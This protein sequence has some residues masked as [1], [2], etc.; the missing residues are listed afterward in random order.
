MKKDSSN[1]KNKSIDLDRRSSS[2]EVSKADR[3][4]KNDFFTSQENIASSTLLPT[5]ATALITDSTNVISKASTLTDPATI[6]AISTIVPPST[7]TT[8]VNREKDRNPFHYRNLKPIGSNT[9][10]V[11]RLQ[12]IS[13]PSS[14]TPFPITSS[15]LISSSSTIYEF[16]SKEETKKKKEVALQIRGRKENKDPVCLFVRGDNPSVS[17]DSRQW[18]CLDEDLVIGRPLFRVLP[19]NRIGFIR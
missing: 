12:K 14:V 3:T 4:F 11:K 18:G 9:L 16:T 6:S 10:L 1:D 5:A 8:P 13:H 2:R 19:L 17:L 7:I 15:P